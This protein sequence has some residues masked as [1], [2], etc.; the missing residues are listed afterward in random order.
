MIAIRGWCLHKTNIHKKNNG[1]RGSL[2]HKTRVV[3]WTVF[4]YDKSIYQYKQY[5]DYHRYDNNN[6]ENTFYGY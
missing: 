6:S 4:I 1:F 5:N 2:K 3:E